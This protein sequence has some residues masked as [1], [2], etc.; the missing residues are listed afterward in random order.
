MFMRR[1]DILWLFPRHPTDKYPA[2]TLFM[3][4]LMQDPGYEFPT[5]FTP[6]RSLVV[7]RAAKLLGCRLYRDRSRTSCRP[8]KVGW[9]VLGLRPALE[10]AV[11][12]VTQ[13]RCGSR[14]RS[15][16]VLRARR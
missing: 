9:L 16:N 2:Q 8:H 1:H 15:R 14:A 4:L 10:N 3:A 7:S 11:G 5:C 6:A 12:G 13:K